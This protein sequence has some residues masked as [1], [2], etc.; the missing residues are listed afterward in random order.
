[1]SF[2]LSQVISVFLLPAM[3]FGLLWAKKANKHYKKQFWLS[4]CAILIG[5]LTFKCLPFSQVYV[6]GISSIYAATLVFVFLYALIF[7][8][9]GPLLLFWQTLIMALAAFMWAKIAKLEMLS[10]TNVI[11][12][13]FIVNITALFIGFSLIA[14]MQV[15]SSKVMLGRGRLLSK[16]ILTILVIIALLPLSGEMILASMK[17]QLIDLTRGSLSYVSRVTNFYWVYSYFVLSLGFLSVVVLYRED[18]TP[19]KLQIKAINGAISRRKA[20]AVINHYTATAKTYGLILCIILS[21]LFYWDMVASQPL[22]RSPATRIELSVDKLVHIPI[23]EQVLDGNIHRFEWVASDGKLVRFFVI[24]RYPGE[25]K[26]G[27]VFDACMLCGDAGYIQSG[28]QVICLACGVHIFIPSIGKSGGCNPIPIPNW[29]HEGGEILITQKTLE[30]G[31][32][33]FSDVVEIIAFDP[34]TGEELSNIGAE[35]TYLFGG[36][37]YFFITEGSY[38]AFRADPWKYVGEEPFEPLGE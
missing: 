36:K 3:L 23:S 28:E 29:R 31:L 32:Q 25:Q 6:L 10:A 14:F 24:D 22:K 27:V 12:T 38:E 26:F 2:Y 34:V 9:N 5:T 21:S 17:L 33:Y 37:T 7:R 4:L 8:I 30:S 13:E 20:Q 1:M 19:L 15:M 18:V 16:F 35:Y 11:N